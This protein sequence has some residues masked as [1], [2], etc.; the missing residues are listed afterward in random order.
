MPFER[1]E[2]AWAFIALVPVIILYLR[3]PKPSEQEIPSLMFFLKE[4]GSARLHSMLQKLITSLL[5]LLQLLTLSILAFSVMGFFTEI[6][7]EDAGK[8]V[9][10]LDVSASMHASFEDK[11]RFEAAVD[12]AVSSLKGRV[13][14]VL[15]SNLPLV[16]LEDGRVGE[17]RKILLAA[18]PLETTSNIG[19]AIL[20][21]KDLLDGKGRIIVLSDFIATEGLDPFVARSL[22]SENT[23]VRFVNFGG[24]ADNVGIIALEPNKRTTSF[25]LRNFGSSHKTGILQIITNGE[26]KDQKQFEI[27]GNSLEEI[28]FDTLPGKTEIRIAVN[29]DMPADNSAYL[30]V[31]HNSKIKTLLITNAARSNLQ[32]AL[33]ASPDVTLDVANPPSVTNFDYDIIILHKFEVGKMLPGFYREFESSV[34]AGSTLVITAQEDLPASEL[35][36]LPVNLMGTANLSRNVINV[37]NR[38]TK[39]IDFGINE[40]YLKSEAKPGTAT[41]VTSGESPVVAISGRGQGK[42]LYY[43]ILDDFSSFKSSTTYPQFWNRLLNFLADTED[44]EN[45]NFNT[46]RIYLTSRQNVATPS[47]VL[48]TDKIVFDRAGFYSYDGKTVAANLIDAKESDVSSDPDAFKEESSRVTSGTSG[49]TERQGYEFYLAIAAAVLILAELIYIK[50]RGDL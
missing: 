38:F 11:T 34:A 28:T 27:Q 40:R 21:A 29:D 48:N 43:G 31:P 9:I 4:Q 39:D 8:T 3:R 24:K 35:T 25:T 49:L 18:K 23:I 22:V 19:D 6:P 14:I 50:F 17:A 37:T 41:I 16:A 10:V 33:E 7:V 36:L 47:G 45:F 5:F 13:S 26:T 12:E 15:S 20:V 44:L 1:I 32:A 30:S 46:G 2:G 42:V